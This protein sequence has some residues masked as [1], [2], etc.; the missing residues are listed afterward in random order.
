MRR[1]GMLGAGVALMLA[2]SARADKPEVGKEFPN[3]TAKDAITGKNISL[4]EL[5]GK[6]VLVDYW[7][8]W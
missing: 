6:V 2:S 7:A 8:T 4:K 5:R 3:F 1:I